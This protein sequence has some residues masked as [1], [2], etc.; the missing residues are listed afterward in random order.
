MTRSVKHSAKSSAADVSLR[1][2]ILV[3]SG[4]ILFYLGSQFVTPQDAHFL[5][6]GAAFVGGM[7]GWLVGTGIARLR[8]SGR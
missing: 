4:F 6:W 7:A 1:T 2:W 5:H 3:I 8:R